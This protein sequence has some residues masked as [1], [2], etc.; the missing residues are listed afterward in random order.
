MDQ[1]GFAFKD[2]WRLLFGPTVGATFWNQTHV[3][4]VL[5]T[6]P[7]VAPACA[8]PD[9]VRAML[10]AIEDAAG[11]LIGRAREAGSTAADAARLL[12]NDIERLD[13]DI[14][15]LAQDTDPETLAAIERQLSQMHQTRRDARQHLEEAAKI[16]RAQADLLEVKRLDREDANGTLRAI[17]TVLERLREQSGRGTSQEIELIERLY[18]LA[19]AARRRPRPGGESGLLK[20]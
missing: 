15:G 5:I 3:S 2:A 4:A 20:D 14:E 13:A 12:V 9:T 16:M 6:R 7:D 10:H 1:R 18:A 11:R 19:D 17:W 8:T